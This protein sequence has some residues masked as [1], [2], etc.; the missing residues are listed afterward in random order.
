MAIF[1]MS[2]KTIGRSSG[3]SS[4]ASSAYRAGEKIKDER[5][6]KEHDYTKKE[7]VVHKEVMLPDEAPERFKDRSVLWNEVE[8]IEKRKDA[9][10]A[11]EVEIALPK[12]LNREEQIEVL[13]EY[14][15]EFVKEGMIADVAMHDNN[16]GN[17]H[18][19]IMLTL[20]EVKKDGFGKKNRDWNDKEKLEKWRSDWEQKANK[21][22]ERAGHQ[23]RINHKSYEKQGIEKLPTIHLGVTAHNMEKKGIP[24]DR[25]NINREIKQNNIWIE[26]LK[27][28]A[29]EV[30]RQV[31]DFGLGFARYV[32]K[33]IE[34]SK[35]EKEQKQEK[36]KEKDSIFKD[37]VQEKT[38][39]ARR[40]ARLQENERLQEKIKKEIQQERAIAKARKTDEMIRAL[41]P[42]LKD[43]QVKDL[44]QQVLSDERAY[45]ALKKAYD[46]HEKENNRGLSL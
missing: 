27:D 41:Q 18:A 19:H 9:Q 33:S 26:R 5:Q 35:A 11:R 36:T 15:N 17:P 3:R 34:K 42:E 2:A 30:A 20:R 16:K 29:L 38:L 45:K 22:L 39:T 44:R 32:K 46:K 43:E 6:N 23:E 10:L 1:H 7:G 12:E 14:A 8:Q 25:G 37:L 24:T 28:E 40:I 13:K 21:A 4:V 31:K